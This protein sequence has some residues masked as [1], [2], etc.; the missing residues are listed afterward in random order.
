MCRNT[1]VELLLRLTESDAF[2]PLVPSNNLIR[3]GSPSA[4]IT[5]LQQ[6]AANGHVNEGSQVI[7][8][9]SIKSARTAQEQLYDRNE[10]GLGSGSP[11]HPEPGCDRRDPLMS[12]RC[13]ACCL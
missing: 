7:R 10:I 12:N 3:S 8:H 4:L 6:N 5:R 13:E 2:I 11:P 1:L 9:R